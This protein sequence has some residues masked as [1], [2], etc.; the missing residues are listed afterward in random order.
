MLS[1]S[2]ST[3]AFARAPG[4]LIRGSESKCVGDKMHKLDYTATAGGSLLDL[5]GDLGSKLDKVT[6]DMDHTKLTLSFKHRADATEWVVKF[7][8]FTDHFIMGGQNW[9]CS[10]Q[11]RSTYILRR[12][13]SASQSE[14]LGRDLIISTTVARYDEVFENAD[15]NFGAFSHPDC[16][17]KSVGKQVCLGAN[18]DCTGAAKAPIPLYAGSKVTATCSDCYA[19]L[20]ADVFANVSIHGFKVQQLAAGFHNVK[21]DASL[22]LDAHASAQWS[23]A[24]DKL[25]T[26]VPEEHLLDFK[27]GSVPFLLFFK[28]PLELS[29]DLTFNTA[30]EVTAGAKGELDFG[31]AYVMWTPDAHWTHVTPSLRNTTLTPTVTGSSSVDVTGQLAVKP[32]FEMHFDRMFSYTLAGSPTLNMELKGDT[33]SDQLCLTSSYDVELVATTEFDININLV[34]FHKDWTWGPKTVGSWT[35][36]PIQKKCV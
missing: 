16:L 3:L 13:I 33:T 1:L 5:D 24:T 18:S 32:T 35:G 10:V 7:H 9:N 25:K 31:D 4:T 29:A 30:A 23:L 15:I 17:A 21:M 19:A 11:N 6:C 2:L 36:Q 20:S 12:V 28:V 34:D 14:H 26:L 22:V 27:V 8:D